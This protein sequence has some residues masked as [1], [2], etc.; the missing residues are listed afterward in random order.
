MQVVDVIDLMDNSEAVISVQDL[1][2][3]KQAKRPRYKV[4]NGIY[5]E[6]IPTVGVELK[7]PAPIFKDEANLDEPPTEL[8]K[9]LWEKIQSKMKEVKYVGL[10][11]QEKEAY[12]K[13]KPLF[14]K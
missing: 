1:K 11:A 6:G 12:Q 14:K 7:E 3:D 4:V 2:A 9:E 13:L 5:R 8:E 10:N